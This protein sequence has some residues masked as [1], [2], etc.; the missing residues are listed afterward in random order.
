MALFNVFSDP[1]LRARQ[2]QLDAQWSS[3]NALQNQCGDVPD[4]AWVEFV[5][6]LRK[7]RTFYESESDWSADSN[8][9][10]NSWQAKAQEW[11]NRLSTYGCAGGLGSVGGIT[12]Q[13]DVGDLGIPGVKDAPA[14]ESSW[15]GKA[16][17]L[18]KSAV[19]GVYDDVTGAISWTSYAIIGLIILVVL[20]LGYVLTHAKIKTAEGSLG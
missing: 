8:N 15:L 16:G 18:A 4:T 6:D 9:A 19:T 20:A 17:D 7:W 1:V 2:D 14:N 10:T 3:L 5:N 13:T 11:A 12:I